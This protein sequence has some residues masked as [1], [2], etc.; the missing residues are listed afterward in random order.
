MSVALDMPEEPCVLLST[1]S[2]LSPTCQDCHCVTCS[3]L[4]LEWQRGASRRGWLQPASATMGH[5]GES[6]KHVLAMSPL[7]SVEAA[8]PQAGATALPEL[9]EPIGLSL[10]TTSYLP[11]M[12]PQ[13][14]VQQGNLSFLHNLRTGF[15]CLMCFK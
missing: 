6:K 12:T 9:R 10:Y 5:A 13:G 11:C 1:I 15:Q 3:R 2:L 7:S 14:V 4:T 8:V